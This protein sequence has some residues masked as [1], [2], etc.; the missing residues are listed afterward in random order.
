MGKR[1]ISQR[2]GKGSPTYRNQGHKFHAPVSYPSYIDNEI[3]GIVRDIIHHPGRSA[4]N[5]IVEYNGQVNYVMASE[6]LKVNEIISAGEKKK[7]YNPGDIVSLADIPEGTSIYGIE[8]A[9]GSG[10]VFCRTGGSTAR[11]INKIKDKII[12][13]LPSKKQKEF[14]PKCRASIGI[15]AAG[16]RKEK[17]IRK[18]GIHYYMKKAKNKLWPIVSGTSMNAVDHPYGGS[19]SAHHGKPTIA[20]KNAPPGAKVGKVKPRRTGRR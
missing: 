10:P 2:R 4:P 17:P 19:S 8:K 3:T 9:P 5:A 14:D 1:I 15:I 20:R 7:E 18:A 13:Q 12:V 11:V 16:G 6:G